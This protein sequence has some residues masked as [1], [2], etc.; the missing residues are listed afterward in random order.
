MTSDPVLVVVPEQDVPTV[1]ITLEPVTTAV[2]VPEANPT[3]DLIDGF[4]PQ[5]IKGDKGDPG[6]NADALLAYVYDQISSS[7][8][9]DITHPLAF[10]PNVTVVDSA[11]TQ[12]QGNVTYLSAQH[13]S[14]QFSAAFA[15]T[16]YLS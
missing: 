8:L 12:V 13:L 15:G 1:V 6:Q 14:I 11:G 10:V 3:L 9:W 2:V 4:G 16:A 5:G 7:T